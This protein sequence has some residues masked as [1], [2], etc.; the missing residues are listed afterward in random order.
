M[1]GRQHHSD[2]LRNCQILLP[3]LSYGYVY[4][5]EFHNWPCGTVLFSERS[6]DAASQ[7]MQSHELS[8]SFTALM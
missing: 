6:S 8:N 5:T 3:I 2:S 1:I 4:V 7:I